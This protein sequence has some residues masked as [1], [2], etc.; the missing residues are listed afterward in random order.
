MDMVTLGSGD[1]QLSVSKM[2]MGCMSLSGVYGTALPDEEALEV[3]KTAYKAGIRHF[4]TAQV[5]QGKDSNGVL[6]YNEEL[7][8]KFLKLDEVDKSEVTV[9]T[10]YFPQMTKEGKMMWS[11]EH[12]FEAT[13]TSMKRLGVKSLDLYYFHR[14]FPKEVVSVEEAMEAMKELVNQGKV[15]RVGLS[16]A[17]PETIRRCHK[18]VPITTIQQEWSLFAY[19]LEDEIVP[20]CKELGIGIVSYSPVARGFLTGMLKSSEDVK[21]D[22][23]AR[24][25]YLKEENIQENRKLLDQIQAIADKK[26][27]TLS[28]ICIAWVM[29]QASVIFNFS[30][31]LYAS[32]CNTQRT[33][34][35]L[36]TKTT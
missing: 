29:A 27:C 5:Y 23:R 32:R 34:P 26:N 15:K 21:S 9:A 16:E 31:A 24:V 8:G 20:L 28:Q 13:E 30:K 36:I 7:L 25:P 18:V 4:D 1:H 11:K 22:W 14:M 19:D 10:K 2:G 6:K 17:S 33:L 3:L 12:F 35:N